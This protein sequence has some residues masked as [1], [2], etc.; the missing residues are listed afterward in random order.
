MYTNE[1][2]MTLLCVGSRTEA[3]AMQNIA[4]K[5]DNDAFII[6]LNAREVLGKGFK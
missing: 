2:R 6:I 5:I 3:Y 1:K 4:K